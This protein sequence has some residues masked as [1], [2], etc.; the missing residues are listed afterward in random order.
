[1]VLFPDE[2]AD[3]TR[4]GKRAHNSRNKIIVFSILSRGEKVNS[5]PLVRGSL[6]NFII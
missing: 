5:T 2:S 1:M 6:A 4:S 3:H